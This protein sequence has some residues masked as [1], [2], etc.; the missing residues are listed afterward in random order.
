MFP[1]SA[2]AE[3]KV[4]IINTLASHRRP[5]FIDIFHSAKSKLPSCRYRAK[6]N[7][8]SVFASVIRLTIL[9]TVTNW[10]TIDRIHAFIVVPSLNNC[11]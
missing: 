3:V 5:G 4:M 8:N 6:K 1:V 11:K 9:S 2:A 10:L 7:T